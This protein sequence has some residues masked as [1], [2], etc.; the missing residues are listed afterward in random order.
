MANL[1]SILNTYDSVNRAEDTLRRIA[2]KPT[3]VT[4]K[5][6]AGVMQLAQSLRVEYDDG[7]TPSEA[8]AGN[9]AKRKLV[10]SGVWGHP[11][12][13]NANIKKGYRVILELRE[14]E[15]ISVIRTIGEIQAVAEIV[16]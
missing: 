5:T 3:T 16:S 14:Y 2:E 9:A 4:F 15:V 11:T 7:A 13:P 8:P 1:D 12:V 10:I 6:G